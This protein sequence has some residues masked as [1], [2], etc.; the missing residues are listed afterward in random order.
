MEET[1]IVSENMLVDS[2]NDTYEDLLRRIET[3]LGQSKIHPESGW[4]FSCGLHLIL[5]H[6]LLDL[7]GHGYGQGDGQHQRNDVGH[8]LHAA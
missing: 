7:F 1:S 2:A 5:C 6:G 8:G 3:Y 4:I